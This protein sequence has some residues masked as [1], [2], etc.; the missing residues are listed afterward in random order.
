M[1]LKKITAF[2]LVVVGVA[3]MALA[4][5]FS[6]YGEEIN[7]SNATALENSIDSASSAVESI[8]LFGFDFY[9]EI[10][11]DN[12]KNIIFSPIGISSTMGMAYLGFDENGREHLKKIPHLVDYLYE[13]PFS[14]GSLEYS[15]AFSIANAVWPSVKLDIPSKFIDDCG[16]YFNAEIIPLDY[17]D[18]SGAVHR[19]N[20]WVGEH[21][22]HG[23]SFTMEDKFIN[24]L[25]SIAITNTTY[26]KEYWKSGFNKD[27]TKLGK[28]F[29]GETSIDQ[30]MMNE[31]GL[32][33]Y[34]ETQDC[35]A[36][37]LPY[38]SGKTAMI[39]ILPKDAT[40]FKVF[41]QNFTRDSFIQIS[42]SF[43]EE[44]VDL[45]LPTFRFDNKIDVLSAIKSIYKHEGYEDFLSKSKF[46]ECRK[47][48]I[49]N[50]AHDAFIDVNETGSEVASFTIL[51]AMTLGYSYVSEYWKIFHANHPFLFY[52]VDINSDLI[53]YIGKYTGIFN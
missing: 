8:N 5:D 41:E 22:S 12:N 43:K 3:I 32:M 20:D 24:A 10:T 52:I 36:I 50:I 53:L 18:T 51:T 15:K 30:Y 2:R 6:I 29:T 1:L 4:G 37:R 31:K 34:T 25:T 23:I 47:N 17:E 49:T 9:R 7:P 11:K 38:L 33:S 48:I 14:L 44:P 26:F 46:L 40:R 21:T 35:Q 45:E 39:I 42:S 27:A 13:N 28:F 16:K 19:I